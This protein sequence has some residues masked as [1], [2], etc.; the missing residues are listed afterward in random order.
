M[1]DKIKMTAADVLEVFDLMHEADQKLGAAKAAVREAEA[2]VIKLHEQ[3]MGVRAAEGDDALKAATARTIGRIVDA[4][5][6][7][8]ALLDNQQ[9][10]K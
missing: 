4:M 5:H 2:A 8:R 6:A 7:V 3:L 10:M 9:V 1:T